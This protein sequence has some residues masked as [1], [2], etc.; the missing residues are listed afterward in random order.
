[1]KINLKS[2]LPGFVLLS[3]VGV[4]IAR[5]VQF[6]QNS[7]ARNGSSGTVSPGG[8]AAVTER[9]IPILKKHN[10]PAMTAAIV[11]TR[12]IEAVCAVG[13]RKRGTDVPVASGDLWHL[14]SDGKA[15][16][17]TLVA[18]LVEQGRLKWD[19]TMAGVFPELAGTMH[20]KFKPVTVAQLL[21][22]RGG[23][24]ANLNLR[25]YLATMCVR[26]AR[27]P[28]AS[29]SP[30]RP[31]RS[32]AQSSKYSNLGYIIAAAVIEKLTDRTWEQLITEELFTP[33]GM[34]S[35]GFGGTGTPG[36]VDQ[37]W[38]HFSNGKPA[39][40]NGPATDTRP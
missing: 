1:M 11:T 6:A 26:C 31:R 36:R 20:P 21:Q 12:G 5:G 4:L 15:M 29:T 3:L 8:D 35:A 16:T 13:V 37:P 34:T 40:Q 39:P 23:L 28:C 25:D 27:G 32:R 2:L 19:T 38:P 17:A 33:L 22:H 30:S 14:G 10:L 24:P 7:S 9:L 18:K